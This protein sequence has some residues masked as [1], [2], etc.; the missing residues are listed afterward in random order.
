[1]VWGQGGHAV[2]DHDLLGLGRA[3]LGEQGLADAGA[4]GQDAPADLGEGAHGVARGR[5]GDVE[6]L[7]AV[8]QGHVGGLAE[9][10]H[11]VGEVGADPD[12]E[13]AAGAVAQPDQP[14]RARSAGRLLADVAAVDQ[15]AHQPVDGGHRQPGAVDQLGEGHL[16]AGVGHALQDVERPL[17]GL[18]APGVRPSVM[19]TV[20][21]SPVRPLAAGPAYRARGTPAAARRPLTW[22]ARQRRFLTGKNT[23]RCG[24]RD[25]RPFPAL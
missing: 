13:Q 22:I 6:D 23:P 7:V 11:Q 3:E 19:L 16:A 5:L 14:G 2:A 15:G 24:R 21:S 8:E 25:G 20:C 10:V 12:A 9:G 4:V 17:D 1:M 18:H